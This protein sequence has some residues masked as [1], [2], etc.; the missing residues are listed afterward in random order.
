[1]SNYFRKLQIK[2]L[3]DFSDSFLYKTKY[4]ISFERLIKGLKRLL[5]SILLKK[6]LFQTRF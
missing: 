4:S 1:M 6:K 2:N 3:S 5:H